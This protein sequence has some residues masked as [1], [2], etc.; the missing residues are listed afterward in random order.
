V[1]WERG[2]GESSAWNSEL[3]MR[4]RHITDVANKNDMRMHGIPF[5]ATLDC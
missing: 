1:R 5:A 2:E 4:A 3:A